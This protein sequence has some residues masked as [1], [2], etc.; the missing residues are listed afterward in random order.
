VNGK[1]EDT[2][3]RILE[4]TKRGADYIVDLTGS[5]KMLGIAVEAL[6]PTGTVALIGAARQGTQAFYEFEDIER[7]FVDSKEGRTIKPIVR[8]GKV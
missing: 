5:P 7:A 1:T 4:I 3:A 2:R 8:I 6:V